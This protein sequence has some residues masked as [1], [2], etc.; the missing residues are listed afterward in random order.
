[1]TLEE[2]RET[3]ARYD[4][5]V[6]GFDNPFDLILYEAEHLDESKIADEAY[7]IVNAWENSHGTDKRGKIFRKKHCPKCG[8]SGHL[9]CYGHIDHG[10]CWRCGGTGYIAVYG[11]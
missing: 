7:G 6:A 2:A 8:G 5:F 4:D 9:M 1:M 3:V 10:C 11:D